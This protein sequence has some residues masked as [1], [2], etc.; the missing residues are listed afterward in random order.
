MKNL[1]PG[2]LVLT[3]LTTFASTQGSKDLSVGIDPF[4]CRLKLSPLK[5]CLINGDSEKVSILCSKKSNILKYFATDLPVA[6]IQYRRED[7]DYFIKSLKAENEDASLE[8]KK[9]PNDLFPVFKAKLKIKIKNKVFI[10]KNRTL[11]CIS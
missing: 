8:I 11:S 7:S 5:I 6:E 4:L 3:S 9:I 1:I 2:I 10:F